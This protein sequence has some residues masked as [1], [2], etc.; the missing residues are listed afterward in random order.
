MA[1]F[2][3]VVAIVVVLDAVLT[4]FNLIP[5]FIGLSWLR[6]HFVTLGAALIWAS[7]LLTD[8]RGPVHAAAY[9]ALGVSLA[10]A[11]WET[12]VITLTALRRAEQGAAQPGVS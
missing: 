2:Y 9:I 6:V 1:A 3:L 4:S 7:I 11:A 5:R 12:G 8:V 10:A